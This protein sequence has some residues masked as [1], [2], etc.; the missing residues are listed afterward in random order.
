MELNFVTEKEA[1]A[2]GLPWWLRQSRVCLQCGRPEFDPWVR[3]IP[4]RKE[5]LLTLVLLPAE[6]H[7][8]RNLAGYSPRGHKELDMTE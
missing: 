4:W 6:F 3:K 2:Q 1:S 7:G 5:W 8:Q